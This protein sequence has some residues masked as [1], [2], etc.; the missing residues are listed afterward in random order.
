MRRNPK[1]TAMR[2]KTDKQLRE[3][4]DKGLAI[5]ENALPPIAAVKCGLVPLETPKPN[6]ILVGDPIGWT[7]T[8]EPLPPEVAQQIIIPTPELSV[9]L[10]IQHMGLGKK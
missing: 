4:L 7:Q 9:A 10:Q 3:I 5:V 6:E 1:E 2:F 8:N